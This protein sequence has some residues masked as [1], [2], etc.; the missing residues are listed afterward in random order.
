MLKESVT[1][2]EAIAL[3]NEALALDPEAMSNLLLRARVNC[4]KGLADHP[5]IQSGKDKG[6]NNVG[7]LGILNGMFGVD[8][9][10]CGA[11]SAF[12]DVPGGEDSI[13]AGQVTR[14]ERTPSLRQKGSNIA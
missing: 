1:V 8:E 7:L 6:Q 12:I 4:N 14:F 10:Q 2:D 9:D 11:I 5:T 13:V 3:L